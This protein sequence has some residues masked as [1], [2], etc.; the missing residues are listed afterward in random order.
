MTERP[1]ASD[2]PA[3]GKL[4]AISQSNYIPWKGYFDLLNSVHEFILLDDAQYTRRD[5]RNRNMIKTP[6]GLVWLTIPVR[7][8]GRSRQRVDETVV[9]DP[10]WA[11]RHWETLRHSYRRAPWFESLQPTFESLYLGLR[12]TRL[13]GINRIF[14]ETVCELLGIGTKISTST[15]YDPRGRSTERLVELCLQAGATSYLTVPNTRGYLEERQ[16]ERAGIAV[17]R[18]DYDGYPEYPQLHGGFEH[19]VSVLDL[20]FNTGPSA[21][22][23]L[24]SFDAARLRGRAAPSS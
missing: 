14:L 7:V 5:W 9:A 12:E 22:R 10:A 13:S 8:K 2:A 4:V 24:K 16:F 3:R 15:D 18:I 19:R 6:Q 17:D 23:Y 1:P 11:S 21:T 20:I